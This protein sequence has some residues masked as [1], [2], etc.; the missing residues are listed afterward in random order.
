MFNPGFSTSGHF[1][2]N[3]LHFELK[4][5]SNSFQRMLKLALSGLDAFAFLY[6][7]YIIV[8]GAALKDHN[9]TLCN[10]LK[11]RKFNLKLNAARFSFLKPEVIYL[12]A[13]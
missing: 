10:V 4:I 9:E 11:L 8:C 13:L 3:R 1:Q 12:G 6:V 2:F 7:H 5:S